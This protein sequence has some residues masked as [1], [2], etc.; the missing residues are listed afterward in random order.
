[1]ERPAETPEL[2]EL[3]RVVNRAALERRFP[4]WSP[5]A[6]PAD[7]P[8]RGVDQKCLRSRPPTAQ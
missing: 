5:K 2:D 4:G 8:E 6:A 7:E 1:M 3:L